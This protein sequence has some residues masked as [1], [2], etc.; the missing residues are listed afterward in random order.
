MKQGSG[1]IPYL[2]SLSGFHPADSSRVMVLP[3]SPMTNV[4]KAS[5]QQID[6]LGV[7]FAKVVVCICPIDLAHML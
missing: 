3:E 1:L 7:F 4:S 6:A 2:L 5:R